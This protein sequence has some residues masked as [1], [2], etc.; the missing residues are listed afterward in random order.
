MYFICVIRNH[1]FDKKIKKYAPKRK[2]QRI[3]KVDFPTRGTQP[4]REYHKKN[5]SK[6]LSHI[7]EGISEQDI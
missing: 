7:R 6:V 5:E 2:N 1:E 4:I 3:S